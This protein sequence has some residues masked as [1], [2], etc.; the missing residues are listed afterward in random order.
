MT[1]YTSVYKIQ[2][3]WPG[4]KTAIGIYFDSPEVEQHQTFISYDF[5]SLI[6][7]VG[8]ILGLT[9]GASAMSLTESLLQHIPYY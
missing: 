7:E 2:K 9:L 3:E 4:N 5:L 1:R 8:G 6:G